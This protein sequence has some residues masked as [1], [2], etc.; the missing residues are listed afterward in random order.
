MSLKDL[1]R[2]FRFRDR[3]SEDRL[4]AVQ[5][6]REELHGLADDQLRSAGRVRSGADAQVIE[7]FALAAV[8]A[9]RVLG[10]RMF[11]VQILGALALQRGDIAEMQTGE[12]KTLA[13]VPAAD[14]VRA[15]AAAACMC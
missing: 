14:L 5:R 15:A 4:Q 12:G 8:I 10:L 3:E 9:E 7:T 13:A 2:L 6:R 11:D 1:L